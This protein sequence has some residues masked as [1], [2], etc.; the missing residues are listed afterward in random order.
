MSDDGTTDELEKLF[1]SE[2]ENLYGLINI[3]M[4]GDNASLNLT[5]TQGKIVTPIKTFELLFENRKTTWRY[6]FND[7][8][9]VKNKDDVKKENGDSKRLI[10]KNEQPLT[11]KGFGKKTPVYDYR[12]C[13]RGGKGVTNIKITEKNGPVE[14]VKLVD[15]SEELMLISKQGIGIRVKCKGISTIGRA[16]QGVRVMRM[17]EGDTLGAKKK[18]SL[19]MM[20]KSWKMQK[21]L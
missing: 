17:S 8:Q 13:G 3:V 10:T 7:D 18:S 11:Q 6:I 5:D 21:W 1:L 16:T 4:K 15:G 20:M 14:S 9:K 19:K 12:L 2:K